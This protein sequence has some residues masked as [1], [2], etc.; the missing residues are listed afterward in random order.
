M[1]EIVKR[2][3]PIFIMTARGK[4]MVP[5][6]ADGQ[7]V[8]VN[9]LAFKIKNPQIGDVVLVQH[10]HRNIV[11]LKRITRVK[12]NAYF[13]EGDNSAHST[14]S[15]HFGYVDKTHIRGKVIATL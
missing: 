1:P 10:P 11:I 4:S 14:D 15:R 12:N 5:Y 2:L 6:V 8:V 13:V 7:S 9:A 3:L